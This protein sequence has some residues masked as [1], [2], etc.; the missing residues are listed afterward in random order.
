MTIPRVYVGT[1]AKY[2]GGSITGEWLDLADYSV[3]YGFLEACNELHKDEEDPEVM[4]QDYEGFPDRFYNESS[5]D[6]ELWK[7]LA[8]DNDQREI[9]EAL[10]DYGFDFDQIDIDECVPIADGLSEDEIDQ[11]LG[12]YWLF[13]SGCYEVP[14]FLAGYID[15]EKFGRDVRIDGTYLLTES[16]TLFEYRS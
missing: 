4:F 13:E 6:E 1:Y 5:I 12:D 9:A 7:W 3:Y 2:N 8:L 10:M 14:D 11:T 16:G 15:C